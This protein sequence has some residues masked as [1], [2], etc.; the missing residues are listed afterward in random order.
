VSNDRQHAP[1]ADAARLLTPP[2]NFAVVQ[3]PQRRFPG[4]V[5]QGDSLSALWRDAHEI[6]QQAKGSD[7]EDAARDLSERLH[8]VL[9]SY[10]QVLVEHEIPLPFSYVPPSVL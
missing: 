4:V 7:A 3:L 8:A 5:I 10:M 6:A 9:L 2:H 1:P